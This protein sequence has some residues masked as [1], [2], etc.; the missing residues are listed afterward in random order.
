[1]RR[2][3]LPLAS[4]AAILVLTALP[5]TA[6]TAPPAPP[7]AATPG[8]IDQP[9]A[10]TPSPPQE[11]LIDGPVKKVDPVAKT[12]KVGWLLG[13]FST[14]LEVTDGTQIAVEGAKASLQD[15]REGDEVKASY[16]ARDGKYIA[17]SI[18]ATHTE[19][20]GET[21]ATSRAPGSPTSPNM[22]QPQ[23]TTA[24]PSGGPKTQ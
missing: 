4:A 17:K 16:E 23:E 11:K 20:M 6:Q 1:M 13:L 12:V 14:T 5:V 15:I 8:P 24:P 21:G 10:L 9:S 19:A 18:E 2:I 7:A 3:L 22:M